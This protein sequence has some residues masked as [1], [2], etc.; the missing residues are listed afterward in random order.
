[1]SLTLLTHYLPTERENYQELADLV[2]PAR[3]AYCARHG[4][5]HHVHKGPYGNPSLY[6]AVQRL[7]LLHSL[8]SA[9]G[10]TELYWVLNVQSILTNHTKRVD[11]DLWGDEPNGVHGGIEGYSRHVGKELNHQ[12]FIAHDCHGLNAGSFVV[13]NTPWGREWVKFIADETVRRAADVWHE[14]RTMMAY[15]NHPFFKPFIS[16]LP[17]SSI[18]SFL[19]REYPPWNESTP[20][21]WRPGDLVLSLPGMNL[22]RRLELI[23]SEEM[24]QR[25]IT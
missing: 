6:Y 13:R 21:D 25:I 12:F 23:R 24:K 16:I 3:D 11:S 1:M 7:Y 22:A 2:V 18:N 14:Q 10:A 20:G 5:V 8:M 17:Q 15:E 19:Y 9:P 4:Y